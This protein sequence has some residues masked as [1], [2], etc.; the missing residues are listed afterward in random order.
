MTRP[1]TKPVVSGPAAPQLRVTLREHFEEQ[2]IRASAGELNAATTIH[3]TT[4][5]IS[6]LPCGDN[7]RP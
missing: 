5:R 3:I 1:T 6:G 7:S 2:W 4:V